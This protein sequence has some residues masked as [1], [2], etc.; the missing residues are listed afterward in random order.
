MVDKIHP[1]VELLAARMESNPEEFPVNPNGQLPIM[2]RWAPWLAQAE[3]L[4]NDAERTLLY[5]KAKEVIFQRIHEEVMDELLN[6][7]ERRAKEA[8]ERELILTSALAQQ[9][10][11]Q[12]QLAAQQQAYQQQAYQNAMGQYQSQ[13]GAHSQAQAVGLAGQSPNSIW[14]DKHAIGNISVATPPEPTLSSSTINAIR[15][16]LKL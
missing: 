3:H 14:V 1:V 7:P 15:K 10:S 8:E 5:T 4:M 13:L 16:A 2:G 12:Q 11:V 6:G 9:Q